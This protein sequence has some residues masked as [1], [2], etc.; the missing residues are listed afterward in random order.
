LAELPGVSAAIAAGDRDMA[1]SGRVLVRYSGTEP[2]LRVMVEGAEQQQIET[3]AD[4]IV[5]AIRA[6]LG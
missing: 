1:G 3:V 4:N 5:A 6:E 2:L